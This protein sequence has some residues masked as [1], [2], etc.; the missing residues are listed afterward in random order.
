MKPVNTK[1]RAVNTRFWED[2]YILKLSDSE[3]LIFIYLL[4]NSETNL[5]GCYEITLEKIAFNTGIEPAKID[6]IL[7]KL[8]QDNKI[9]YVKEFI[10]IKNFLKHQKINK[11]MATNIDKTISQLPEEIK[12]AYLEF[13]KPEIYLDTLS[14]PCQHPVDTLSTLCQQSV[15]NLRQ[16]ESEVESEIE[17][18]IEIEIESE[19]EIN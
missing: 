5:A 12:Q 2:S 7:K 14:T 3:K 15:D 11:S 1:L 13:V 16:I 6:K 17:N 9:R 19:G 4:T 10:I 8:E 18:E